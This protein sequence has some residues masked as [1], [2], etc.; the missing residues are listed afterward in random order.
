MTRVVAVLAGV[1]LLGSV[2]WAAEIEGKVKTWDASMNM[3]TLEDGTQ[4]SVP[5]GAQVARDQIKEGATLKVTYEE[6]EGKK[7]VNKLEVR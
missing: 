1:L 3:L 4:L 2:A 5:A 7:V 6:K